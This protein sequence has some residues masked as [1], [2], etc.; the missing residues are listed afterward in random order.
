MGQEAQQGQVQ[1]PGQP[2][3]LLEATRGSAGHLMVTLAQRLLWG[4]R[5]P[6]ALPEADLLC[7]LWPEGTKAAPPAV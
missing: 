4:T 1:G 5:L 6:R 7:G 2:W 3:S